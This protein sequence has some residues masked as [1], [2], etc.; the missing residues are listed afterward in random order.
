MTAGQLL[1]GTAK[2]RSH[3]IRKLIL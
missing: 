1:T 2:S 3:S